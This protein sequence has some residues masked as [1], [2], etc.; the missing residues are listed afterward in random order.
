MVGGGTALFYAIVSDIEDQ[1]GANMSIEALRTFAP[2]AELVANNDQYIGAV[3][4]ETGKIISIEEISFGDLA[5][6]IDSGGKYY[7][8]DPTVRYEDTG[9]SYEHKFVRKSEI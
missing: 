9:Y 2:H 3:V 8:Y 4:Q 5:Y 7:M 6:L 1:L